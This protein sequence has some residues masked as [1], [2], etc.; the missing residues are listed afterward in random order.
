MTQDVWTFFGVTAIPNAVTVY[1][2]KSQEDTFSTTLNDYD[3]D[4][5]QITIGA[6]HTPTETQTWSEFF[7]GFLYSMVMVDYDETE[8]Y[9]SIIFL[10][11]CDYNI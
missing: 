6:K 10:N 8:S 4:A 9:F 11:P 7:S 3:I 5:A 1:T 2:Y